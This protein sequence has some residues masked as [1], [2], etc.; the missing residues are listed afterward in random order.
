MSAKAKSCVEPGKDVSLKDYD[1]DE[2]NNTTKDQA[3]QETAKLS[4]ELLALQTLLY[5]NAQRA[6][7]IVLQGMDTSGKDGVVKHVVSA[8]NPQGLQVTSFKVPTEDEIKHDFLWRV[9]KATPRLG[10]VGIFNRSHYEDVLV[11]RVENIVPKEVWEKRYGA[12]N[13]F[14]KTLT[15]A[16]VVVVK[17]FLHITKD[18]QKKRLL[19][20]YNDPTA[21]WKFR[22]SDLKTRAKWDEYMRA[23]EVALT[24]CSTEDAPWYIIP[25]N[26]KWYRNLCVSRVLVD[27]LKALDMKW[28]PLEEA[29]RGIIIE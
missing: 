24:R 5:A 19:D 23:Y 27:E 7:L 20:R 21:Q 25:S 10:M 6:L 1:P 2:T 8:F 16:G 15:Q 9:H 18:E 11:Q 3:L 26:K 12:I 14:E 13:D 22:A 17:F 28:P 4:K 29:A